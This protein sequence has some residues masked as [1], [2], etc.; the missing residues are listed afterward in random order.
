M[1]GRV[2]GEG[3]DEG[4]VVRPRLTLLGTGWCGR[5]GRLLRFVPG[6]GAPLHVAVPT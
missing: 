4:Q 1:G 6:A 3:S 2:K 5:V